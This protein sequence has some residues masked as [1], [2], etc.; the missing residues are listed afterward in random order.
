M[1]M[2][3]QE[4]VKS[5]DFKWLIF[6]IAIFLISATLV[7]VVYYSF[8]KE[9]KDR[10]YPGVYVGKENLGGL[11]KEEAIKILNN[12]IDAINQNGIIFDYLGHKTVLSPLANSIEGEL[13]YQ[14]IAFNPEEIVDRAFLIGRGKNLFFNLSVR[15]LDDDKAKDISIKINLNKEAIK[16]LLSES[17][18]AYEM[19]AKN[20][21]LVHIYDKGIDDY[22]F[23]VS[24]EASG[25]IA[26][27]DKGIEKLEA[28]LSR[29]DNSPITLESQ[30]QEPT[31]YKEECSNIQDKARAFLAKA[32]ITLKFSNQEKIIE[33]DT[34]VGWLTLDKN[35]N[36]NDK[37]FI[38]LD[39]ESVSK[40]LE[41]NIATEVNKK[42]LNSKFT[43][44][45]G[46]VTE[47]QTN[48]DGT[49]LDILA[50][51]EK[52]KDDLINDNKNIELVIKTIK[53]D[54]QDDNVNELNIVEI[55]GT[56]ESNFSGSPKNRRHNIKI[57]AEAL[58][59]LLIKPDEE[60]AVMKSLVPID[61]STGY[62]PELVIKDNKTIPEY[63]GGLCQIG[64]T[65]FRTA[66]ASGLPITE[67]RNHSYRVQYYEPA[68]TDATIYDPWPDLKFIND[69]DNYILIQSRIEG[70][71]LYFD[72]WGKRDGRSA[73]TT[74]PKIY[75]IIKPQPTKIIETL[76]L[77]PGEKKC[78]ERAHNGAD[79]YFNYTVIYPNGEEKKEKFSS[80]YVPWREVCL[81]GVEKLS[82]DNS[83]STPSADLS[84]STSTKQN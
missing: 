80:H 76:D 72:F 14:I 33:K 49:E 12:K 55:I 61:A 32:P 45:N 6:I 37:I 77:K 15:L 1:L 43:I 68:G 26:N 54:V 63:G 17:F 34:L 70:D 28:N 44:K 78:T 2:D 10:I 58:N 46:R 19:P 40:Y 83:S 65:M 71:L 20:A 81:L 8:E 22:N 56:G 59:G 7:G 69:T 16:R 3:W 42:P 25:Q 50:S 75:N 9:Y 53:S 74:Y 51:F 31:I 18:L 23:D 41:K 38:S 67:R 62:L 48:Q 64:T 82:T 21:D 11:T 52:I 57:G 29:L 35:S 47:F 66:L 84:I 79:A 73:T 39:Q 5:F 60:F 30:K 27:Y 13:A 24:D 4:K 36:T